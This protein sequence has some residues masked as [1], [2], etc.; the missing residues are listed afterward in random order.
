MNTNIAQEEDWEKRMH[1]LELKNSYQKLKRREKNELKSLHR[2]KNALKNLRKEEEL[3]KQKEEE[4][5][6]QKEEE[7]KKQKEEELK[8]Q[9]E[10]ELKKLKEE[11]LKKQK[12]EELK[13]QKE[14]ELNK[15][16]IYEKE[17]RINKK[18]KILERQ[19]KLRKEQNLN[20]TYENK[21]KEEKVKEVLE[22][23]CVLGDIMKDEIVEEKTKEPEKFISIE[24]ATK[25][26]NKNSSNFCLGIL[27]QNLENLGIMTAIEKTTTDNEESQNSS[28]TVLQF[29]TNGMI[30]KKKYNLHFDLGEERNQELLNNEEE[31]KKFNDKLRK[32]LSI[33][34]NIPE[35]K[36][37]ITNPQRGSYQIQVIFQTDDFNNLD[38]NTLKDKCK[39]DEEF[40][41]IGKLKQVQESL[42]MSACK[43]SGSMLDSRGNRESGWGVG[44]KR[45]GFDYIPPPQGWKGYG[46]KVLGKYDNGNDDWLAYNGNPNEWAIAYHGIGTKLGSN[47]T[48]EKATESILAGGFKAGDGQAYEG[49]KND[50]PKCS[51]KMVGRGVYC[52]PDP[53]VMEGY[54][55]QSSTTVNQKK[56]KMGFMMR[57]KPDKIR[58]SNSQKNY[59]VLDG[60]TEQMRPYRIMVKEC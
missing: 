60:T 53:K 56:Y 35:N 52:S 37:I 25:E 45:G 34:Y 24:E 1:E 22:D 51:D 30:E 13:K 39:N 26:E 11:E 17:E 12:E 49:Y 16:F 28:N 59:W 14:E 15:G 38:M 8:K 10:E 18:R 43:L 3:K 41:E 36:I 31:Q 7:L 4:L 2:K 9:K 6:K 55:Q 48:V 23:M 19:A 5:K 29:I 44:E 20:N 21:T 33:E 54:A 40:K 47:F 42:I 46:L 58:Y 27:A 50:N 57:V 32:K